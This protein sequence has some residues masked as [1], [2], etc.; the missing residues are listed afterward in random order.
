LSETQSQFSLTRAASVKARR[1]QNKFYQKHHIRMSTNKQGKCVAQTTAN[2]EKNV[3]FFR[4]AH[5]SYEKNVESLDTYR[6]I[7]QAV[8]R[9]IGG[10]NRLLDIGNGGVFDYSTRIVNSVVAMDLFFDDFASSELPPNVCFRQGSVLSIPE[11]DASFDGVLMVMLLHHLVGKTVEA[12]FVNVRQA[13]QETF[14]VL[15]P[16]GKFVIVESCAPEWFYAFEKFFFPLVSPLI[17]RFGDHPAALQYPH[18]K[19]S[20]VLDK[21]AEDSNCVMIEKGKWVLQFGKKWPSILTPVR[22][23]MFVAHKPLSGK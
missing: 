8:E 19:I 17:D 7:R 6:N 9:E 14:R 23:V 2:I 1:A 13:L 21:F 4:D 20:A 22:P 11:P 16:G 18:R 15:K 5:E 3:C 10:I 12:S